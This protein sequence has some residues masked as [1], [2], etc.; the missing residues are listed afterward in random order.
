V[1]KAAREDVLMQHYR[2]ELNLFIYKLSK[3]RKNNKL[4]KEDYQLGVALNAKFNKKYME[5]LLLAYLE[6]CKA[7]HAFAFI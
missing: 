7:R 6:R 2:A 5:T 4:E 3:A 1:Y